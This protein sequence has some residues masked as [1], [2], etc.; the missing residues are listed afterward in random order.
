[1]EIQLSLACG[2]IRRGK[3]SDRVLQASKRNVRPNCA[4]SQ[5]GRPREAVRAHGSERL[6]RVDNDHR[7]LE[8][9]HEEEK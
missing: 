3:D 2:S 4:E 6:L 5:R 1:M 9:N 7:V 8:L